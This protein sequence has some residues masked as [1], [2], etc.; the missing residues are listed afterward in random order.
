[1]KRLFVFFTV[2]GI[3][4][5]ACTTPSKPDSSKEQQ[6][7]VAVT[8][9][10]KP[11]TTVN[12]TVTEEPKPVTMEYP[13]Y[14]PWEYTFY[15]I[16][17]T[18][19][20][21]AAFGQSGLVHND[22]HT[23]KGELEFYV[24]DVEKNNYATMP[25]FDF[26]EDKYSETAQRDIKGILKQYNLPDDEYKKTSLSASKDNASVIINE[27]EHSLKLLQTTI[28]NK[29][30]FELQLINLKTGQGWV[31]QKDKML[32]SSRGEVTEYRLKDAYVRGDKIAVIIA[33]D[34]IG[35]VTAGKEFKLGKFLIVTGSV[36]IAPNL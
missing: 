28:D 32:P 9:A 8:P 12:T 26:A 22:S 36:G 16:S 6:P 23:R 11:D 35:G 13:S 15:G 25:Y 21:V 33:Y 5:F 10:N 30:I 17:N 29:L 31:L 27:Q 20:A 24:V 4:P 14:L 7:A 19:P 2:F 3:L 1:M 34:R 18:N